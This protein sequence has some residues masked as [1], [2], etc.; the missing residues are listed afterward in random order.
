MH[1]GAYG[2]GLGNSDGRL[3]G[4]KALGALVGV[5]SGTGFREVAASV[6]SSS[7]LAITPSTAWFE[8]VAWDGCLGCVPASRARVTLVAWT[9]TD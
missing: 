9:D 1:G 7:W 6:R 8:R 4:W 2:G 5:P 3:A